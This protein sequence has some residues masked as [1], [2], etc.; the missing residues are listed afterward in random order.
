MFNDFVSIFL[1]A[2]HSFLPDNY[3]NLH[4]F[5]CIII[6]GLSYITAIFSFAFVLVV[7]YSIIKYI[8]GG[9]KK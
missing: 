6:T 4:W 3:H 7:M 5:D 8:L 9:G 2:L 1:G